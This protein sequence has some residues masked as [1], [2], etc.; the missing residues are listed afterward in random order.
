RLARLGYRDDGEKGIPGRRSLR[1]PAGEPRHHLYVCAAGAAAVADHL[2][3]REALRRDA[4]AREA[5]GALKL[6]LAARHRL[7]RVA[8]LDGKSAFV[9][10]LLARVRG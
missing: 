6:A 9:A 5:Y 1:W 2:D 3:L 4:V 8:Y 10:A 7:D